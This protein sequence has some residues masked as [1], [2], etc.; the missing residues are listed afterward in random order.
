MLQPK[1][2]TPLPVLSVLMHTASRHQQVEGDE[3]TSVRFSYSYI[4]QD[5]PLLVSEEQGSK[6]LS[7]PLE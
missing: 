2:H 4:L 1:G 5:F 7:A 3:V 6:Y